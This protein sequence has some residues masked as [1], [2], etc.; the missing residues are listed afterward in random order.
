MASLTLPS[1]DSSDHRWLAW[2]TH[3]LWVCAFLTFGIIALGAYV[4]LM[5]AG[6][7][8]PDWPGCYGHLGVPTATHEVKAAEIAYGQE[9]ETQKAWIEMIHRYF[10][11]LLGFLLIIFAVVAYRLR[12]LASP[13]L[14]YGLLVAVIVQG[15]FGKWTVTL[16]LMP[17]I[18]TTHL[19]GGMAIL[20]LLT[21]AVCRYAVA[22]RVPARSATPRPTA[23]RTLAAVG[24]GA[25]FVQIALGGWTSTNYAAL[26]CPDLPLCHGA[27]VPEN[28]RFADG[29]RLDR[30]LGLTPSGDFLPMESLI[31]IHWSHRVGALLLTALLAALV[32]KLAAAGERKL[33]HS[34][35]GAL[36]LQLLIGMGN[37]VFSLPLYLAVAHNAGAALLVVVLVV[38]NYR[39]RHPWDAS[40]PPVK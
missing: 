8:C 7:G 16:K 39:L 13:W 31:A 28:M 17:A 14:A 6:L 22:P 18:V 40:L 23:L 21:W 35:G 29:F 36:L 5:D 20:G 25:L 10:A 26:A 27:W 9:V 32:W 19:L 30:A 12:H 11:A 37:V 2:R 34:V 15:I 38:V 4:R 33:A 3:L 1:Q 24:L